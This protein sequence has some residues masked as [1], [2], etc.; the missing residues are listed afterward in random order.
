MPT[1]QWADL[2]RD[3][4]S[5]EQD[6]AIEALDRPMRHGDHSLQEEGEHKGGKHRMAAFRD[7][8]ALSLEARGGQTKLSDLGQLPELASQRCRLPKATLLSLIQ[9][10]PTHFEIADY[11]K[12]QYRIA[13]TKGEPTAAP[14]E[15]A[16]EEPLLGTGRSGHFA[17]MASGRLDAAW[18]MEHLAREIRKARGK[19]SAMG[20]PM[21]IEDLD[22]SRNKLSAERLAN[23]L[24]VLGAGTQVVRVRAFGCAGLDDEAMTL[25]ASWLGQST[26]NTAPMELHLSGNGITDTGF[27]HLVR[28]LAECEAYPCPVGATGTLTPLYLRLEHNFI[29]HETIQA[30]IN[31]GVLATM[32]K[33][34]GGRYGRRCKAR[35]L[36]DPSGSCSQFTLGKRRFGDEADKKNNKAK[37]SSFWIAKG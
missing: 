15:P 12:G 3:D 19:V 17:V 1:T 24:L 26:T 22:I 4:V 23:L 2:A 29:H 11:G 13:L 37:K 33:G 7:A 25:L 21:I 5:E 35:L 27:K 8:C 10:F 28:A 30:A 14:G 6:E 9:E 20:R 36:L 16:L 32:R 18:K 31:A 34:E